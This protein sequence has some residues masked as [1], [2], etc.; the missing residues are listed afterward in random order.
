M[1]AAPTMTNS[2]ITGWSAANRI[3]WCHTGLSTNDVKLASGMFGTADD[4]FQLLRDAFDM[5]YTEGAQIPHMMS[6]GMHLRIPGHPARAAGLARFLDDVS[7]RD[8]MW[9]TRRIDIARH[10]LAHHPPQG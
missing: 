2:R 8:K 10:W 3:S 5:L 9:V 1:T 7:R 4:Y 6:V